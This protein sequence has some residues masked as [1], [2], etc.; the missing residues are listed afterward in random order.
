MPKHST[1][2]DEAGDFVVGVEIKMPQTLSTNGKEELAAILRKEY[3]QERLA[4]SQNK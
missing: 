3:L 4:T 2:P 1:T